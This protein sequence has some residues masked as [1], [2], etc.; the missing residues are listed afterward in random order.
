MNEAATSAY[1][2]S[3][4]GKRI[5]AGLLC[6]DGQSRVLLVRPTYKPT[7]EIPGGIVEAGESSA[8]A[9]ARELLEEL[10]VP[11]KVGRILVIDWL[12]VRVPKTE[13]LM[14]LFD[15]GVIDESTTSRF[16][17]PPDELSAWALL[18]ADELNSV[19]PD[20]M[21]RRIRVALELSSTDRSAYLEW[22]R[23]PRIG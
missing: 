8:A 21:A 19:V 2:K 17:L 14:M 20:F 18:A 11:L 6:R 22:G 16:T 23:P 1:Y 15:G 9:V 5:G 10:G 13:G 12:P 4:P 7:W 3:L